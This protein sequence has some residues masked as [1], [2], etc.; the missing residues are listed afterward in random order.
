MKS[1]R[2]I[3]KKGVLPKLRKDINSFVKGERGQISKQSALTVGSIVGGAAIGAAISLK[4]VK[5]RIYPIG[6]SKAIQSPETTM[7]SDTVIKEKFYETELGNVTIS[8]TASG[9]MVVHHSSY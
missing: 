1:K 7:G 8:Y 4:A 9:N 3:K 2:G 5:G 6:F